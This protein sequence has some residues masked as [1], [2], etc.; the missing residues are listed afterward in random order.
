[1]RQSFA[2]VVVMFGLCGQHLEQ[3]AS[4]ERGSRD[5]RN[6]A[7]PGRFELFPEPAGD[8]AVRPVQPYVHGCGCGDRPGK[9]PINPALLGLFHVSEY[10]LPV[11]HGRRS[12]PERR[13]H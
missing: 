9:D 1:M 10:G 8:A 13:R 6:I 7:N 3:R 4:R 5:E 12:S 2:V 11:H